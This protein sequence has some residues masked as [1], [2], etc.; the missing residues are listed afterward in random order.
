ME[1]ATPI[2]VYWDVPSD[3]SDAEYLK[4]V[5]SDIVQVRPLMLQLN[6][7]EL[8]SENS[9][10]TLIEMFNGVPIAVSLTVPA[11]EGSRQD[12]S[13]LG[14]REL[15]ELL[16]ASECISGVIDAAVWIKKLSDCVLPGTILG[17][18]YNTTRNNWLDLPTVV[19]C[20]RS[21]CL[22]RLVLPMQRLYHA[23][24]PFMLTKAEQAELQSA[25]AAA[26]GI[27][28][29]NLTI[30]D[31]FLWKAFNPLV[32]FPQAGCQAAN[33]MI[34]IANDGGVYPC[35]SLPVRL[36]TIGETTLKEIVGCSAKKDF[37]K[38]LLDPPADCGECPEVAI[39]R[40][41]CRGR[42]Y[43]QQGTLNGID[44]ACR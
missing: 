19:E 41:G 14:S 28:G 9:L 6:V 18:S 35:P 17:L 11:I 26:G 2:T 16:F 15:K 5:C 38:M 3:L 31:P 32:P 27:D 10:R 23:E 21:N 43:V 20:C 33:T 24:A 22:N 8:S 7:P 37:R 40:G 4:R 1:L 13:F 42:A 34:S 29:V 36:G 44:S 25:L 30:H 12:W 39:C